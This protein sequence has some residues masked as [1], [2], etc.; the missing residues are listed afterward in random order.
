MTTELNP[1]ILSEIVYKC[2]HKRLQIGTFL[3]IEPYKMD[4]IEES[5][6][7]I[8][9]RFMSMITHWS[10]K[11]HGTGPADR[12]RTAQCLYDAVTK[13]GCSG[14]ANSFKAEVEKKK[15]DA[16]LN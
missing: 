8:N 16:T 12:P 9:N 6:R 2:A 15:R 4:I 13:A 14:A 3:G 10:S 5:E 1:I 11:D 7:D